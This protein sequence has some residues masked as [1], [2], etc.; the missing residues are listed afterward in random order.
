ML[1]LYNLLY[2]CIPTALSLLS[3]KVPCHYIMSLAFHTNNTDQLHICC[4]LLFFFL[5][6]VSDQFIVIFFSETTCNLDSFSFQYKV[7]SGI[8]K[9]PSCA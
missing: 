6:F 2:I 3:K 8:G 1:S 4:Q 7:H 9:L 5:I